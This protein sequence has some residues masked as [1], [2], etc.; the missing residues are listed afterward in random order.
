M[1][2][3]LQHLRA[4]VGAH[5]RVRLR[6]PNSLDDSNSE[7]EEHAGGDSESDY[8]PMRNMDFSDSD[9]DGADPDEDEPETVSDSL[10]PPAR[11]YAT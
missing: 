11:G 9:S 6:S 4:G 10:P 7:R 5:D 3:H 2:V 8:A 1:F